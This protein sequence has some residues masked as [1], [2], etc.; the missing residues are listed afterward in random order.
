MKEFLDAFRLH[1]D[2][3]KCFFSFVSAPCLFYAPIYLCSNESKC[4]W[5]RENENTLSRWRQISGNRSLSHYYYHYYHYYYF[6]YCYHPFHLRFSWH[7][8][9]VMRLGW[10][11]GLR[12]DFRLAFPTPKFDLDPQLMSVKC[13][14]TA[15]F[16]PNETLGSFFLRSSSSSSCIFLFFSFFL[17]FFSLSHSVSLLGGR[18]GN[19]SYPSRTSIARHV[20]S[21]GL[22]CLLHFSSPRSLRTFKNRDRIIISFEQLSTR[23]SYEPHKLNRHLNHTFN[24]NPIRHL[25]PNLLRSEISI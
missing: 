6:Y 8:M 4:R 15:P 25:E 20:S 13:H 5:D 10:D 18:N 19:V 24:P 2:L 16:S 11:G 1:S 22:C 23:A 17:V 7:F 12:W 21:F 9:A 3:M 14:L